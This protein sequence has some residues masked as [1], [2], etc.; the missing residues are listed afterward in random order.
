M[1][2]N[3]V[4]QAV[5][6]VN[7]NAFAETST[8]ATVAGQGYLQKPS[9]FLLFRRMAISYTDTNPGSYRW[10]RVVNLGELDMGEDYYASY[11][12]TANPLIRDEGGYFKISPTPTATTSGAAFAELWYTK[13]PAD[14]TDL[15]SNSDIFTITGITKPFHGLIGDVVINEIRGKQGTLTPLQVREENEKVKDTLVPAAFSSI[16]TFQSSVPND[17]YLQY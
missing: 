8:T 17:T 12:D 4:A 10:G 7:P 15:T 13:L 5:A 2:K 1:A 9:D 3:E 11:G 14:F 16:G 6:Q